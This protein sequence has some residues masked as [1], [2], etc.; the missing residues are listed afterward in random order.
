M[1]IKTPIL[2]CF[3]EEHLNLKKEIL[4]IINSSKADNV[5]IKNNS[6]NDNIHRLDWNDSTNFERKWVKIFKPHL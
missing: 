4:D 3:F 1:E 6:R 2:K 5:F